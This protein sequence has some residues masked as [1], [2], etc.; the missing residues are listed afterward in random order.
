MEQENKPVQEGLFEDHIQ[1][2]V[3]AT[4]QRFVNWLIDNILMQ[5]GLSYLTGSAVGYLIGTFFPE[6]AQK[7]IYDQSTWDLFVLGYAIAIFNYLVYYTICEKAFKGYT[8]GKLITGT[9]AIR[10][11][12][13]ELT[14]KDA[15]LR[16]LCRLVPFEA[17]SGFG[18][19]P[20][21]DAW[22]KTQVIQVR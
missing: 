9:K 12:G 8:L 17:F 3:A 22:T 7:I 11:D 14:F 21:H 1:Y 4:G 15:L 18:D 6:Y 10:E 2:K 19:K 20:W 13:G 5:Y 16:S